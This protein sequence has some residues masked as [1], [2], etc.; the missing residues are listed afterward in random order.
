MLRDFS[1]K[2]QGV[3]NLLP[4]DNE[5]VCL[6]LSIVKQV[7]LFS[8]LKGIR[9]YVSSKLFSHI[10]VQRRAWEACSLI[11]FFPLWMCLY[12]QI[13]KLIK[14]WQNSRWNGHQSFSLCHNMDYLELFLEVLGGAFPDTRLYSLVLNRR[15]ASCI[16]H[17]LDFPWSSCIAIKFLSKKVAL[18]CISPWFSTFPVCYTAWWCHCYI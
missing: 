3:G 17:N 15:R 11:H 4:R 8:S 9:R 7:P 1:W 18:S 13:L 12:A 14:S 2:H 10:Q 5:C 6:C 16:R